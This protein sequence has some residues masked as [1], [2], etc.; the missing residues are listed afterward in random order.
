MTEVEYKFLSGSGMV[1]VLPVVLPTPDK[2]V[3]PNDYFMW[4]IAT[5][6]DDTLV[7]LYARTACHWGPDSSTNDGNGGIRMVVRSADGGATWSEPVDLL[8]SGRWEDSPFGG[9]GAGLGVHQ[10]TVYAAL[11]QGVYCSKD[12]GASWRLVA[13]KPR[14][15]D[16]PTPLWAP[17]MR[18]TF[19]T[20]HGMVIWTT[21]GY[22]K[23]R[24][25]TADYGKRMCAVFSQDGGKTWRY[26]DQPVPPGIGLSEVTPLKFGGRM[27]FLLRNGI[28]DVRYAQGYSPTGWF[29]FAFDVT[30]IGPVGI[31]DTPDIIFNPVSKRFEAVVSH[32]RGRGPGPGGSMKLN[33]YSIGE[34]E[35]ASGH[36]AWR[37]EGTLLRYKAQFGVSDGFNPV[38]SV[39]DEAA[40]VQRIHVWGGDCTGTAG[41]FQYSR[42]LDTEALS[43]FLK[44]R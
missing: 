30:N 28:K 23:V 19:D 29:P 9:F 14:F 12:K 8:E 10:G 4:P 35:L 32:R 39:V 42:T 5:Q 34:K 43:R 18:I 41:I 40:G 26:E 36:N 2:V 33:L 3:G 20:E 16:V 44:T 31:V 38:G 21:A 13:E 37:F 27:A 7:V 17:G 1:E 15:D 6:V 24:K 11:N 22:A 25:T